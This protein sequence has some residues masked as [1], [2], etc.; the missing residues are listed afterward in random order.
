MSV[1]A[2]RA[3]S[4]LALPVDCAGC[5]RPDDP[6]C[7][8]CAAD[9]DACLWPSGPR[10]SRPCPSP[11]GLPPVHSAGRYAGALAAVV[12]AYKDD[13][14]RQHGDLLG[15]LLATSLDSAVRGSPGL[16]AVLGRG[17]G[18]VLVVP[19]PSSS[20]ARRRR[21]DAP[22]VALARSAVRGFGT[23]E[24]VVAEALVPRRRVADQA[25]LGALERAVNLEHSM[26]VRP[27]WEPVVRGAGCVVVDD[28]LT[29][30]ATLVEA[31]RALAA[32][33]ARVVVAAT[34]CATQR[35]SGRAGNAQQTRGKR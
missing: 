8:G 24:A 7:P 17:S 26:T 6:W 9:L 20:A 16:R 34:I 22:L 4:N 14:R 15:G 18:P 2:L 12:S 10:A 11:T 19:V 1:D 28:V 13:G 31:A 32:A 35:R 5:G 23:T 25:G 3:L 33:D 29:T 21:G 27:R 30:G